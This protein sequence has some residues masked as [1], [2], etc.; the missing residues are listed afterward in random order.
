[1]GVSSPHAEGLLPKHDDVSD[2]DLSWFWKEWFYETST[3]DQAVAGVAYVDGDPSSGSVITHPQRRPHGH[4]RD[5]TDHRRNDHSGTVELPVEVWKQ[6][7]TFSFRYASTS[8]V[9]SVVVDP[10]DRLPD[11]DRSNNVWTDAAPV[12]QR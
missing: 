6:G 10:D 7:A 11:M 3:L 4:A 9:D 12:R 1:L 5:S 2:E 8:L